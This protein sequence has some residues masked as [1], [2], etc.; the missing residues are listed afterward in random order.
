MDHALRKPSFIGT[1]HNTR[2]FTH[3]LRFLATQY[4]E[5]RAVICQYLVEHAKDKPLARHN[6]EAMEQVIPNTN[7]AQSIQLGRVKMHGGVGYF[8]PAEKGAQPEICF[9]KDLAVGKNGM[10]EKALSYEQLH[11]LFNAATKE[12]YTKNLRIYFEACQTEPHYAEELQN[13]I[14]GLRTNANTGL[15]QATGLIF[16]AEEGMTRS[17]VETLSFLEK[18]I[19]NLQG[20]RDDVEYTS[21]GAPS[22][23]KDARKSYGGSHKYYPKGG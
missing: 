10:P 5:T 11:N 23:E 12:E 22:D 15:R 4:P 21:L 19:G 1:A 3:L 8:Y 20:E 14:T 2:S 9:Y 13:F 18:A 6:D 16:K 7:T 17:Y